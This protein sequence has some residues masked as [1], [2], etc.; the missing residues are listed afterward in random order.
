MIRLWWLSISVILAAGGAVAE[1]PSLLLFR[2]VNP[3]ELLVYD[4]DD[5]DEESAVECT[6]IALQCASIGTLS[7]TVYGLY[8]EEISSWAAA[9]GKLKVQGIPGL[10]SLDID[11]PSA[12]DGDG[13]WSVSFRATYDK[14][15]VL[16]DEAF[17]SALA[18]DAIYGKVAVVLNEENTQI[19]R[20]FLAGCGD[21][22]ARTG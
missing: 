9:G 21:G 12:S 16:D 14:P 8:R 22:P 11:E 6:S 18:F 13:A 19:L 10:N 20:A 1:T 2:Q 7:V 3:P 4:S 5:C 15:G 17:G